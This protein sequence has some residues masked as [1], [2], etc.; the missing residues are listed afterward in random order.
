MTDTRDWR[1][2]AE[3]VVDVLA[4]AGI[5]RCYTVPGESFLE[6]ADAMHRH[7]RI[8]LV[9]T[10]HEGGAAFMAEADAK[11]TGVPAVAAAT[12]GPGAANLAVGVHTA[13]QDSTPMIVFLGQVETDYLGREAFQEV[14]LTAFYAP[15]TKWATTVTRADRLAEVTAQAVRTATTGRPGPVAIAVPGDL[16]GQRVPPPAAL[17]GLAALP[18]PPLGD[19]QRDRV[20]AWLD[21]ARRPVIIAGGGARGAREP[22]V[23]AAERFQAGVYASWRRQDVFPNDHPL[24]LGHLGLGCPPPV[25]RALEEAD[26]VLVVGCRLSETTTQTYRLPGGAASVAQ[27]DISPD[28]LGAV[29][30]V[31]LGA[32]ADAGQALRALAESEPGHE[33]GRPDRD[34]SPAHAAWADTTRVPAEAAAHQGPGLHP[35]QVV[36]CMRATLPEDSV[37]TNDAGNFAAFLHRGWLFRHP[38][39]QIAPTSGAMGYAI[40]AA[41]GAK[42]AAPHRTVVAVAGDGG[43]LMTGSELETAVRAGAAI[44]VVVFQNGMYGTIAMHQ[45]REL[46]RTAAIDIS[47]PLDLAG[48]ARALGANGATATTVAELAAALAK[49]AAAEG[50]TLIDVRT[51]PDVISPGSTLS[52]LLGEHGGHG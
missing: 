19:E 44:T 22:L 28:Q 8:R 23:R 50:P 25:L 42:L 48:Y 16:F 34:W 37:I 15:I 38:R 26:A 49:A 24:Y 35:W 13:T 33:S 39:T 3:E 17:P 7:D 32:Q 52:A 27:I 36:E 5:R 21:G 10:R 12:R 41:I 11:S 18:A 40:P 9:S 1:T 45:A 2:A 43:A 14:D 30:G 20:A 6:L 47:G 46:G 29:A 31:W 51:D 4:A